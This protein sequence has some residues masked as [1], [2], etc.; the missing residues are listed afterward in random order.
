MGFYNAALNFGISSGV[1]FPW[2]KGSLSAQSSVLERFFLG[3][4]VSPVCNIGGPIALLGFKSRGL[5]LWEPRR[6]TRAKS[7]DGSSETNGEDAVGGD[8]AVT[9]FADL[10]FDLPLKVL[11]DAGIHGH[12]FACA[13]NL[14]KLT[15]NEY[16][17]FS[18]RNFMDSFRTT[19]G[20]GVI[21]PT[22]LFRMEVS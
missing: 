19:V 2:G 3:G 4:N 14:T 21:I 10:S 20:V 6:R 15:E 7:D 5:G 12:A 9:T 11:R 1:V 18:F 22:K 8:L 16:K 13:G 17:R